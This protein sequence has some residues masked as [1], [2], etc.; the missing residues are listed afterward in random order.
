MKKVYSYK[1]M[2]YI[3]IF[4]IIVFL[5]LIIGNLHLIFNTAYGQTDLIFIYSILIFCCLCFIALCVIALNRLCYKVTYDSNKKCIN[6]NGFICG[7]KYQVNVEDIK[8]IIIVPF[9]NERSFFVFIDKF[10]T[11]YD[12][13][14]RKSF[15]RI[16]KNESNYEFIKQFWDKPIK[17]Y[18]TY[19][20]LFTTPSR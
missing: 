5:T 8:E 1:A 2:I 17:E 18:K 7:Y 16:E 13:G 20:D 12:G 6:R 15:I 14:Y 3:S 4:G 19:A 11:K 9:Q 10:N